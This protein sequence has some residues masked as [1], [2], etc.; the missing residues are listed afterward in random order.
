MG[1]K[2]YLDPKFFG[3]PDFFGPKIFVDIKFWVSL[4]VYVDPQMLEC[5]DPFHPFLFSISALLQLMA[6]ISHFLRFDFRRETI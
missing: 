5:V 2:I 3:T 4:V 6:R 1:P